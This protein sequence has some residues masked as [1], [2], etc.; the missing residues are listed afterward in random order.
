MD[1]DLTRKM[2]ENEYKNR[3]N[4]ILTKRKIQRYGDPTADIMIYKSLIKIK[5]Y[6]VAVYGCGHDIECFLNYLLDD[7]ITVE[8]VIDK[9]NYGNEIYGLIVISDENFI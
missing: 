5:K 2:N 3:L 1:C 9:N 8:Y 6:K 4:D 7:D